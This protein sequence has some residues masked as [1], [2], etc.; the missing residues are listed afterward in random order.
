MSA[1][2]QQIRDACRELGIAFAALLDRARFPEVAALFTED[3]VLH[4][5]DGSTLVGRA[6]IFEA[7]S[8]RHT[9]ATTVHHVSPTFVTLTHEAEAAGM[10]SFVAVTVDGGGASP[11]GW[12]IGFFEDIYRR[13]GDAWLIAERRV[14]LISRR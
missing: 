11:N 14:R 4:R 8:S 7:Q 3:G 6:Q 12:S 1:D 10:S 9:A 13:E 5:A 2:P